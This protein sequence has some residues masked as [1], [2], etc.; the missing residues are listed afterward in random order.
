MPY[1]PHTEEAVQAMLNTLGVG[2]I[3][4]LFDEIPKALAPPNM[5]ELPKGASEHTV[6]QHMQALADHNQS[7]RCFAGAGAYAHAIPAA[8][9]DIVGRGEWLTAY[10]PYQAEASQG[11]LQLIYEFQSMICALLGMD[12]ANASV[13]DGATALAESVLMAVR[14][15]R[16]AASKRVAVLGSVNPVY[17]KVLRTLVSPQSIECEVIPFDDTMGVVDQAYLDSMDKQAFD[18]VVIMQ[19]NF[20]GCIESV[21]ALVDWAH[22][23]GAL[24]IG[25]VNPIAMALLKPPGDWGA[26]GCDIACGEGQP[27]GVPM[28][29]GGPYIGFMACKQALVRQMP[30]RIV[31]RT[32]DSEGR[33][34]FVLT[35][36]AREQHIRRGKAT[37]N[38]CTNQGLLVV[39]ATMYMSLLG[40]EGLRRVAL[41]CCHNTQYLLKVIQDIPGVK[42]RFTAPVFHEALIVTQSS[43]SDL[44]SNMARKGV[45]AGLPLYDDF[46]SLGNTLLICATE[47]HDKD[48]IDD[49][50][51]LLHQSMVQG[52]GGLV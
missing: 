52:M 39:A 14:Y 19:P 43:V 12:A 23:Q 22:A 49:Y 9:W 15:K 27:L 4:E 5:D 6:L 29:F 34:G 21:D 48:A 8:I 28:S 51:Q 40:P 36:Q 44:V 30:G 32:S 16:D 10:T 1:I 50:A 3:A 37:S 42:R 11:S 18:A 2:S 17:L 46:K 45:L 41:A 38:I 25:V 33:E 20:F 47:I 35:L 13:Y 31:G 24:A 26:E 7:L